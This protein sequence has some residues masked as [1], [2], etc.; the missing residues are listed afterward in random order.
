M[1]LFHKID[2]RTEIEAQLLIRLLILMTTLFRL[3]DIHPSPDSDWQ[4][5]VHPLYSLAFSM[6]VQYSTIVGLD[7][8]ILKSG[9][10]RWA[11]CSQQVVIQ[12]DAEMCTSEH[13]YAFHARIVRYVKKK[14]VQ[15]S[16]VNRS[17]L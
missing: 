14:R 2:R 11:F 13:L 17:C 15:E 1:F 10:N 6:S 7:Q 16:E 12:I 5:E 9:S 8:R 4:V 3:R